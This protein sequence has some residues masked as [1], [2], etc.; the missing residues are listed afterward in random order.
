[1]SQ[2]L[3]SLLR[4]IRRLI[5]PA[6]AADV[7]DGQLLEQFR[8]NHDEAAFS[9]LVER[10]G[11]LVLGVCKRV[12]HDAHDAEDA[13]QGT[14]FVLARK[15][16][17]IRR[18]E[19]LSSWLY[20]VAYKVAARARAESQKRQTHEQQV[21][22]M[23]SDDLSPA[24]PSSPLTAAQRR[25]L[26]LVL[27]DELSRLPEKY[28]M[29]MVLC[30]LEGK[31]NEEAA[32]Q[33]RWTKGT[34]SGRLARARDLLRDRLARRGVALSSAAIA[35]VVAENAASAAV[36]AGLLDTTVK[37]ACLFTAGQM[38]IAGSAHAA[39]LAQGVLHSMTI[40]KFK[41]A[42]A[43]VLV[44]ALTG[45]GAGVLAY[46]TLGDDSIAKTPG[47]IA[48]AD[49]KEQ[50]DPLPPNVAADQFQKATV[51]LRVQRHGTPTT[52]AHY[53]WENVAILHVL[54]NSSG[55]ELG[56]TLLVASATNKHGVPAEIC[57]IYL[58]PYKPGYSEDH[59]KL[60]N[61]GAPDGISHVAASVEK[62][63]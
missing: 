10:H 24:N 40:A 18:P 46:R 50:P 1:M 32:Q 21:Q 34:V 35:G 29:P 5:G 59:W 44:V 53:R 27:D 51:V 63:K 31:S 58:E 9:S 7:P 49:P 13:F 17:S 19:A 38:A 14:F 15:A 11:P 43:V 61:G 60:L 55:H 23:I 22:A 48:P 12:L 41:L 54:K 57:T 56:K 39:S 30:Y 33:L 47:T 26:R 62:H 45:S 42:A 3:G 28:R 20:G 37:G 6:P 16:G 8:T 2:Q 25:E 52:D 4:H 36:P